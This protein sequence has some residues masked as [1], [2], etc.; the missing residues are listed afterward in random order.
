MFKS[1]GMKILGF[2]AL[3]F[4]AYKVY[5]NYMAS[6]TEESATET[7]NVEIVQRPAEI[8]GQ[9]TG[10]AV[11]QTLLDSPY[12][13]GLGMGL[14][15]LQQSSASSRSA[16]GGESVKST[17]WEGQITDTSLK[18][19]VGAFGTNFSGSAIGVAN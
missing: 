5:E 7:F 16:G 2:G 13:E 9:R 3:A 11:G 4:A 12:E 18:Y 14:P 10:R 1:K 8:Y 15:D 17:M 6:K 19:R